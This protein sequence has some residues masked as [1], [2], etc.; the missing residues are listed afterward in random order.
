MEAVIAGAQRCGFGAAARAGLAAGSAVLGRVTG[1]PAVEEWVCAAW[2][3]AL[4]P[5]GDLEDLVFDGNRS[6]ADGL[7]TGFADAAARRS[8]SRSSSL[9]EA[10]LKRPMRSG[11][12]SP[13]TRPGAWRKAPAARGPPAPGGGARLPAGPATPPA[14]EPRTR[15]RPAWGDPPSLTTRS[16]P[17]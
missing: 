10:A 16:W 3:R 14:D 5:E 2:V 9:I 6:L 15:P 7:L 8:A 11:S 1:V 17:R 4:G 13:G 12:R